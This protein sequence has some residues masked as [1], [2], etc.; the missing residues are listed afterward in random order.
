MTET[1]WIHTL[2]TWAEWLIIIFL[3]HL[4]FCIAV[5]MFL[6]GLLM[7]FFEKQ[8]ISLNLYFEQIKTNKQQKR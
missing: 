2:D 3:V 1:L 8:R 5:F 4:P 6:L 7:E